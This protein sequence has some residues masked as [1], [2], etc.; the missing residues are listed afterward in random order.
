MSDLPKEL[1]AVAEIV[2]WDLALDLAVALGGRRVYLGRAESLGDDH[3]IV[4]VIGITAATTLARRIGGHN[5][6]VPRARRWAARHLAALGHS[7]RE[8]SRRLNLDLSTT[9]RYLR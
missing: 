9:Y 7:P 6:Q 5:I 8:V 2:G 1:V 4:S 3:P